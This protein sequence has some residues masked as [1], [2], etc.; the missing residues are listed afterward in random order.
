MIFKIHY[1]MF[2]FQIPHFSSWL[3]QLAWLSVWQKKSIII[4]KR[5]HRKNI[6][7]HYTTLTYLAAVIY[8]HSSFNHYWGVYHVMC[9]GIIW[10]WVTKVHTIYMTRAI[11]FT[12]TIHNDVYFILVLILKGKIN[13]TMRGCIV[14]AKLE[15]YF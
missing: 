13:L 6:V 8:Y 12:V 11:V 10:W 3:P 7:F 4:W 5:I 15:C 2:C 9:H 1:N 14:C